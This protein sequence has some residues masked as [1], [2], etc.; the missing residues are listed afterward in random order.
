MVQGQVTD[1]TGT[2]LSGASV[3]L[4][5]K[6]DSVLARFASTAP[7]GQFELPDAPAGD[8]WLR[9]T[10][11]GYDSFTQP[12]QLKHR[13]LVNLDRIILQE[14][15]EELE[16]V[17][18]EAE[19]A[20][21]AIRGDTIQYNADA[22]QTRPNAAV[23]DLLKRLPGVEVDRNGT[24]NLGLKEDKKKGYFGT[25][26]AGY[27]PSGRFAAKG[28]LNRF[29]KDYQLS[30]LGRF[31]NINQQGFSLQD[32]FT[33]MGGLQNFMSNGNLTIN[34]S[35]LDID[36]DGDDR[37]NGLSTTAAGELPGGSQLY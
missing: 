18:V 11:V 4:L 28:N 6:A 15:V 14:K 21:I 13:Q 32:Y 17:V 35:D 9:I 16:V 30:A 8:Y 36:I 1:S 26:E 19:R 34:P 37:S 10:Y 25:A 23:E 33:L 20:P 27:G 24:I 3:L 29:T 5:Q 22:F 7:N 31:N 2:P 12:L